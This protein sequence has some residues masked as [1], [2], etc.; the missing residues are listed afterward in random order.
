MKQIPIRN[1]PLKNT[2]EEV[3]LPETREFRA[4]I[5]HEAYRRT[6]DNKIVLKMRVFHNTED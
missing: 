6:S 4:M 5:G 3:I 2:V 1:S